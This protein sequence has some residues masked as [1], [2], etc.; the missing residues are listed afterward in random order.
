[1]TYD[2]EAG[3][4]ITSSTRENPFSSERTRTFGGSEGRNSI[5]NPLRIG[6]ATTWIEDKLRSQ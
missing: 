1:M 6:S 4:D 3:S 5:G 2:D